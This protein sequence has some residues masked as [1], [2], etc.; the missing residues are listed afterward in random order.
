MRK[1]YLITMAVV[2]IMTC[3]VPVCAADSYTIGICQMMDHLALNESTQGFMDAV[4]D[5][6]GADNVEFKYENAAGDTN[7]C[8]IIIN[9]FVSNGVD[10]ILANATPSLQTAAAGT[11]D[12]P[13][14]G[15]SVTEYGAAL[16]IED[17]DG[18]VGDNIS[19]TSDLAPLDAQAEMLMQLFPD[20]KNVGLLYCSSEANSEYQI[21]VVR[22]CL[23]DAGIICTD[24][25]FVNSNDLS[26]VTNAACMTSD[27]IFIPTDNTAAACTGIIDSI[28]RE[29]RVPV[30]GGDE[31]ILAGCGTATLCIEY[32]NLGVATGRMAVRILT[33]GEDISTMPIEYAD[34][35]AKYNPETCELYGL[36]IPENFVPIA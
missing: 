16:G 27:V 15:T 1:I 21:K 9:A 7:S 5:A 32:Y 6:L 22:K 34:C 31:G 12:I 8:A 11:F 18:I 30:Y 28:C 3:A 4:T 20:A 29:E 10:L 2:L 19:G 33:E 35:F 14:L 24:Y 25:A 36:D 17:F 26:A 23:E 13:I